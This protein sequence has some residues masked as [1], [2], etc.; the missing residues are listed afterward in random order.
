MPRK[1]QGDSAPN[2]NGRPEDLA[3]LGH[4]QRAEIDR[5]EHQRREAAVA[6]GIRDDAA[7]ERE[8]DPRAFDDAEGLDGFFRHILQ[9]EQAGIEQLDHEGSAGIDFGLGADLQFDFV[10]V[11]GGLAGVHTHIDVDARLALHLQAAR[12]VRILEREVLHI[13]G[14]DRHLRHRL[15]AKAIFG[16]GAQIDFIGHDGD[17]SG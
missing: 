9:A 3:L 15:I 1:V 7:G 6:N 4:V 13:L 14:N 2:E 17:P 10:H 12:R 8:Q 11:I 16:I 5:I